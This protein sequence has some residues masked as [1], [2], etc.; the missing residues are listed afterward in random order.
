MFNNWIFIVILYLIF[1]VVFNQSYKLLA[2]N[3]KNAGAMTV[4]VNGIAGL[5][6]LLMI[7][8]F[9]LPLPKNNLV[10]LFLGLACVFY[11]LNDRL[12]TT[13]RKDIETSTYS[14]IKQLST[15]FMIFAGFLFFKEKFIITKFTGALLIAISN[16]L[17]FYKKDSVKNNKYIW[18]G[19]L[20]SICTTVAL[21]IDVSYS[22]QFN[23]PVYVAF[24]LLVPSLLIL[25]FE[26]VKFKELKNEFKNSNKLIILSTCIASSLMLLLKL[27][28]YK[29]G[30]VMI[31]A[32]LCSL[33]AILNAIVGYIFLN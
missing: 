27:W 25:V 32:P 17:V 4:L 23:L 21:F 26:R 31:V 30:E 10:Y 5:I 15:V 29:L 14:M 33:T 11:A 3:M 12:S 20:A 19:L 1:A 8:L 22:S 16:V 28:A 18:V 9:D 13:A 2:K 7:P 24:T 6:S